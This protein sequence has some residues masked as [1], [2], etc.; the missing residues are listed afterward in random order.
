MTEI[1]AAGERGRLDISARAVERI[2][3][4][5]ALQVASVTR[6]TATFGR[7]LPK[8][9]ALL[10]GNRVR[11]RVEIAVEW[12]RPLAEIATQVRS[13][14][15][16]TVADLTALRVD[17]VNVDITAVPTQ[18]EPNTAQPARRLL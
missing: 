16:D 4:A 3:E 13:R 15:A 18:P 1:A 12:G 2:A 9:H 11:L 6:Q 10:A 17:A 14:V 8:A 7:G 5:A